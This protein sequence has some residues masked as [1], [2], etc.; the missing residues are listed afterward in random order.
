MGGKNTSV[1]SEFASDLAFPTHA[2]GVFL[3]SLCCFFTCKMGMT[4]P[5]VGEG[6]KP[7]T[8]GLTHRVL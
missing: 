2:R 1:W 5:V 4:V 7:M 8:W 3:P 6:A